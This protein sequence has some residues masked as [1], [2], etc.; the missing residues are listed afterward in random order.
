[1]MQVLV[2][3]D[4]RP[5]EAFEVVDHKRSFYF[6]DEMVAA[7]RRQCGPEASDQLAVVLQARTPALR[8]FADAVRMYEEMFGEADAE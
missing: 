2:E 5:S 3:L 6:D 1:M 8:T 7:H 4:P